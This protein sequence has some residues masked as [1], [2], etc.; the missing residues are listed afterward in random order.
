MSPLQ[1]CD[2][3]GITPLTIYGGLYCRQCWNSLRPWIGGGGEE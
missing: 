1:K 3:C 2:G